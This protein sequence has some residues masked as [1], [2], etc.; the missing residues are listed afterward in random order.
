MLIT[1]KTPNLLGKLAALRHEH[2]S[3]RD[4]LVLLRAIEARVQGLGRFDDL[5]EIGLALLD[6][7]RLRHVE[8]HRRQVAALLLLQRAAAAVAAASIRRKVRSM[9]TPLRLATQS[10]RVGTE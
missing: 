10:I 1:V 9:P 5:L 7:F 6:A 3:K 4:E 2:A 8:I